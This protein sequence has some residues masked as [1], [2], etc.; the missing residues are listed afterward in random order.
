MRTACQPVK[1]SDAERRVTV[2]MGVVTIVILAVAVGVKMDVGLA[3]V[4]VFVRVDIVLERTAQRPQ[5]DAE[6]HH[7]HEPFAPLGE[8]IN[9]QPIPQPERKQADDT[10]ARR[11]TEPPT[12]PRQPGAART[13]HCQRRNGGEMVRSGPHMHDS[14][15]KSCQG[16][17]HSF[18][19]RV[20]EL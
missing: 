16:G 9:R 3:V 6:Q 8:Q 5:P 18:C 13:A 11:M 10:H 4:P 2:V 17:D 15:N 1:D 14:G 7:A 20:Q 12:R 19:F